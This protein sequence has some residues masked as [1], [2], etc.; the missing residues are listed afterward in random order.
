MKTP[1]ENSSLCSFPSNMYWGWTAIL[2]AVIFL[3]AG[4]RDVLLLD[5]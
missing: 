4:L 2:S 5:F 1:R 3:T